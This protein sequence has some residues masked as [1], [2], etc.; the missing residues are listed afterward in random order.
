MST[1]VNF[2]GKS[3]NLMKTS[4][5]PTVR[6]FRQLFH[7]TP[8]HFVPKF[9]FWPNER[10][11]E[12]SPAKTF[13][14]GKRLCRN[15]RKIRLREVGSYKL[16]G[17]VETK[18]WTIFR[19]RNLEKYWRSPWSAKKSVIEIRNRLLQVLVQAI[20]FLEAQVHCLSDLTV[21]DF[22]CQIFFRFKMRQ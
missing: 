5:L 22:S 13:E 2:C 4:V 19:L 21:L 14:A 12:C 16:F 17:S 8:M 11:F 18:T 3:A 7:R 6:C 9:L 1:M 10:K 20:S 15:K